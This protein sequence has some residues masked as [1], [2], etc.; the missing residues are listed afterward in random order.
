MATE[1]N[2]TSQITPS[3]TYSDFNN[4]N[5]VI[6]QS[7]AKMQTA[8]PVKVVACTNSG[9][10][11]PVGYVDVVPMV[12]QMAADGTAVPHTTIFNLPY[13]RLQGGSSAVIIDPKPGDIGIAVFA[14]RD[15]SRVKNTR[16]PGLPGSYRKYSFSDG[17]YLFGALNSAPTQYIQ[18][19]DSGINIYSPLSVSVTAP[20]VTVVASSSVTVNSPQT[21]VNGALTVNGLTTVNGGMA[22]TGASN[23][24]TFSGNVTVTGDVTASGTSLHTHKHGGVTTGSG[25]TGNPV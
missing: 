10:I 7:L 22:Q 13:S 16:K 12:E 24:A 14:S 8:L 11:S 25:Q 20:S 4:L 1:S 9:G 6:Q 17:M 21:T 5:F 15:I 18:F 3:T 23:N 2:A 19:T